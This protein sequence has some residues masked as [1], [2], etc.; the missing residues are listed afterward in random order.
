VPQRQAN[1]RLDEAT[2]ER[3]EIVA[4]LNRRSISDELRAALLT[5]LETFDEKD[6]EIARLLRT[7]AAPDDD[8]RAKVSSL[9]KKRERRQNG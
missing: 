2:Y 7:K 6:L 3:L 4:F 9:E 1:I 8:E 5:W